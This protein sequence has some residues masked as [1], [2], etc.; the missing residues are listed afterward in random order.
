MVV[1]GYRQEDN[2]DY[3]FLLQNWWHNRYLIEVSEAY[4][5]QSG[6][7]FEFV[8]TDFEKIPS[9]LPTVDAPYAETVADTGERWFLFR[10]I[11]MMLLLQK[12]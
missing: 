12:R 10:M 11:Q 9:S 5:A 4:L 6:A 3:V 7:L 2:G 8:T 1:I